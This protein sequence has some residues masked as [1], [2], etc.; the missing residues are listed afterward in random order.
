VA[1][2]KHLGKKFIPFAEVIELFFLFCRRKRQPRA[3]HSQL[4]FS[5]GDQL[6]VEASAT[7]AG[8]ASI[9]AALFDHVFEIATL[10]QN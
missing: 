7:I 10:C 9:P 2:I 6:I 4:S 5:A 3:C 8:I 1:R